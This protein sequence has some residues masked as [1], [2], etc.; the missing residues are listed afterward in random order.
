M[1]KQ[2]GLLMEMEYMFAVHFEFKF[3]TAAKPATF[4]EPEPRLVSAPPQLH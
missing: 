2:K 4:A 3:I 1:V